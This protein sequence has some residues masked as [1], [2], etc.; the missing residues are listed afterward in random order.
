[1]GPAE[2]ICPCGSGRWQLN[3]CLAKA[4]EVVDVGEPFDEGEVL[5]LYR[6]LGDMRRQMR[7]LVSGR[8]PMEACVRPELDPALVSDLSPLGPQA[9]PIWYGHPLTRELIA[10]PGRKWDDEK[11][12][13]VQEKLYVLSESFGDHLLER[14]GAPFERVTDFEAC[15][16]SFG[17]FLLMYYLMTP[18]EVKPGQDAIRRFLGNYYIR[19][20]VDSNLD[21]VFTGLNA[22]PA[23]FAFLARLGLTSPAMVEAAVRECRDWAWYKRRFEEYQGAA[24]RVRSLWCRE[25][26]YKELPV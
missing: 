10:Y 9:R 1:M 16:E 19:T 25:F 12:A 23:Y 6:Q 7:S 4:E 26:D 3:C 11:G 18:L 22:L 15:V 2:K 21:F 8:S 20:Y 5:L 13:V 24:G 17:D 14:C